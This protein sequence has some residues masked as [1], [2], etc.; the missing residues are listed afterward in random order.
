[1]TSN[2]IDWLLFALFVLA[3]LLQAS[4]V[5]V[6]LWTASDKRP[7]ARES[8]RKAL[9]IAVAAT[10]AGAILYGVLGVRI[11]IIDFGGPPPGRLAMRW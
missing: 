1:L 8:F 10:A 6:M 5:L 11:G 9:A 3:A 2:E 7:P 4:A